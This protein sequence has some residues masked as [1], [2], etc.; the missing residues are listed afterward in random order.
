MQSRHSWDAREHTGFTMAP[1][2]TK[3]GYSFNSRYKV[4]LKRFLSD[5]IH[6]SFL[7]QLLR[8]TNAF[9]ASAVSKT[10]EGNFSIKES[11]D[12]A[13]PLQKP[14]ESPESGDSRRTGSDRLNGGRSL[15]ATD[16]L[17]HP[18]FLQ[19]RFHQEIEVRQSEYKDDQES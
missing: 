4:C 7:L 2:V 19:I 18:F 15:T 14:S 1:L 11:V 5:A 13:D 6:T 17:C 9:S 10:L 8:L 16:G 12:I 3:G